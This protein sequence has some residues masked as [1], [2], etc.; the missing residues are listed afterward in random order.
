MS[1]ELFGCLK[2]EIRD[3]YVTI[4]DNCI[5][6]AVNCYQQGV[7]HLVLNPPCS[8]YFTQNDNGVF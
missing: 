4:T 5:M 3:V 7:C 1:K 2:L 6:I 8:I